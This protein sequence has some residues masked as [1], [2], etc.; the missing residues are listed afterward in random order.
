MVIFYDIIGVMA[1]IILAVIILYNIGKLI[2]GDE[3][4]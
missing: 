3:K 2:F 1:F 4:T